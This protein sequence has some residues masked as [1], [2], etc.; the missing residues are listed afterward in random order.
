MATYVHTLLCILSDYTLHLINHFTN[1][2]PLNWNIS[3]AYPWWFVLLCL[4]VGAIYAGL[5]YYK[6]KDYERFADYRWVQFL[7]PI[8]RFFLG[9]ILAFLLLGP[10]L[11][12]AGHITQ[13]PIIALVI[14]DSKSAVQSGV[15]IND[16][17]ASAQLLQKKLENKY[18]V[19][20]VSYS[21][22]PQF[23]TLDKLKG[24]GSETNI[25]EALRY[26]TEQF[27]N[28]NLGAV[29]LL[30]DG[31]YNAGSDPSFVSENY[32]VPLF[33]VGLGDT[34]V[35]ADLGVNNVLHN[36]LAY[37][38]N[39]F[40]MRVEVKATKLAGKQANMQV[41][42]NGKT[43]E[44]KNIIISKDAFFYEVDVV[45]KAQRLGQNKVDIRLTT[46]DNEKNKINNAYMFYVDV[47]DGKKKVAIWADAPHPDL[48]MLRASIN[49]NENY[50]A[51][52]AL[53]SYTVSNDF[54]LV[55]VHNWFAS[56]AQ[57]NLYE[58]LKSSGVP[59]LLVI[60]DKFD[61]RI[62]NGGSQDL[63]FYPSGRGTNAALPLVNSAFEYFELDASLAANIKKWPPLSAAFGKFKGYILSD[64]LLYQ[65]IGSVTT[66][67]PLV[68][69]TTT[70]TFR[71]GVISGTGIW[72]W[73]LI[74]FEKNGSHDAVTGL[75]TNMVQYLAVKED[76][77][78][79]KVYPSA[80]QYG[81]G[82]DVTLLGELYNQSLD[83]IRGQEININLKDAAG[84][85]YKHTMT[86]S[87]SQYRLVLQNL[88]AG[89]YQYE[90]KAAVGGVAL[91]DKGYF[92]IVGQ[93]KELTNLT[94]DFNVLRQLASSTGGRFTTYGAIANLGD[95][96]VLND[97]FKSVIVE[98]N[99]LEDLIKFK[100]L[101][102]LLLSLLSLEWFVRK[103]AGGY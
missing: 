6:S 97:T 73:R 61:S 1:F 3:I 21:N 27:V 15:S 100:W 81:V 29:I 58:K 38:G 94:A 88:G 78:L 66:Q 74:D 53:G 41:L 91:S 12:Y 37:L 50:Q 69:L 84:K 25:S 23:T 8:L 36:S 93:Q 51:E 72:Q 99:K 92:T 86:A 64:V 42:L 30:T 103:W 43:I 11:K 67:E 80:K 39:E 102:W 46:F 26:T 24:T 60:G 63:K 32:K 76:K 33:T 62:F 71:L 75:I 13:K 87:G 68:V 54:D 28:Q 57:L 9:S 65:Q 45:A 5:L 18:D 95:E 70:N 82:E 34:T 31:I 2:T 83:P 20:V 90:A 77:K 89:A 47:I 40:P 17:A 56:P 16:I 44:Q 59:V 14:D 19:N 52:I 10:V 35:Y 7:L 85:V 22:V 98:D 55:I 48:G 96:L 49:S 79:L 4:L 101:F